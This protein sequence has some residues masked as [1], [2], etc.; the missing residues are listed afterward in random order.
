[1]KNTIRVIPKSTG[2]ACSSRPGTKRNR[3]STSPPPLSYGIPR[4]AGGRRRRGARRR[5]P[6]RSLRLVDV[7]EV[8]VA[9]RRREEALHA[10]LHR[11]DVGRVV[12]V[13]ERGIR[14]DLLL[15]LGVQL[16][17]LAVVGLLL[18]LLVEVDDLRVVVV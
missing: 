12:Q 14:A 16:P 13:R 3:S 9:E 6:E 17:A 1:M 10:V 7:L 18:R 15:Q 5:P 4:K 2:I 11:V 8:V